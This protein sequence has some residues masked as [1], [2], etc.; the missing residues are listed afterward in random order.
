MWRM[1]RVDIEPGLLRLFRW[2]VALRLAWLVLLNLSGQ[3][4]SDD[5]L[6]FVPQPGIVIFG[7]LLV[8][9]FATPLQDRMGKWYLP[10][11]LWV[12][13]IGLLAENGITVARRLDAGAT[14]N[15]AVSDYWLLFFMLFVPLI[16]V[17]WQYRYRWVV[18]FAVGTFFLDTVLTMGPLNRTDADLRLVG[19]LLLGRAGLFLFVGLVIVKL[20]GAQ[21]LQRKAL[22]DYATTRE[23]LATSE[24]RSRLAR[25]LHD[26]LAHTLSAVAVQLEGAKSLWDTDPDRAKAMLDRS[27][28]STRTGLTEARRSIR[29]LRAS[30][31]AEQGLVDALDALCTSVSESSALAAVL[32]AEPVTLEPPV[33][34]AAYRIASEAL[35]NAARHSGAKHAVVRLRQGNGTFV[36]AVQDDGS[37]FDPETATGGDRHGIRGMQERATLVGGSLLIK[38]RGGGGT[39]VELRVGGSS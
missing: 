22:A 6:L 23:Q 11:A 18:F 5:Q 37:G 10:V 21:R 35:T 14:P 30:P 8:Y 7:L 17:A 20:V 32:D 12:T 28:D 2:F 1:E 24:E 36:M 9:L 29:A 19:A 26:T 16:L 38:P 13:T 34:H 3:N 39:L 33:E 27:L 25:E 31:L 15:E 4:R